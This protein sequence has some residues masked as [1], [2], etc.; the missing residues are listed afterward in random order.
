VK[1][2]ER[3]VARVLIVSPDA[4]D[5]SDAIQRTLETGLPDYDGLMRA[6]ALPCLAGPPYLIS[7]L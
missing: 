3:P 2:S 7:T 6:A 1:R 5:M 4:G